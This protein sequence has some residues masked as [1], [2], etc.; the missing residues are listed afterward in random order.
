MYNKVKRN[1]MCWCNSGTKYK[2]SHLNIDEQLRSLKSKGYSVPNKELI[3]KVAMD[4]GGHGIGLN[5]HKESFVSYAEH[6]T[7]LYSR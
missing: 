3:L 5:F 6:S 7:D 4:I 2:Y 1:D